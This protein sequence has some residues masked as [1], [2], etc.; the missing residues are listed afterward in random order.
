[1]DDGRW[2]MVVRLNS[3]VGYLEKVDGVAVMKGWTIL[4]FAIYSGCTSLIKLV[5]D[6]TKQMS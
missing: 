4:T 6:A 2:T 3:G 1:M 5:S